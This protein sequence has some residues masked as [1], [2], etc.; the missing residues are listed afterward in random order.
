MKEIPIVL[1][2]SRCFPF[3]LQQPC[4]SS[5]PVLAGYKVRTQQSVSHAA[6]GEIEH[7]G[8]ISLV[9]CLSG[10][11]GKH[12]FSQKSFTQELLFILSDFWLLRSTKYLLLARLD[13]IF[14]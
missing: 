2:T 14:G 3:D 7:N 10:A 4:F 9:L 5:A 13:F 12:C 11:Q 6:V 1:L 8:A